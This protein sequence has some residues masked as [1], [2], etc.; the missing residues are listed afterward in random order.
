MLT[1]F[2]HW[3]Y[4]KIVPLRKQVLATNEIYHV[5][6]R[7]V[8]SQ[9]IFNSDQDRR[10]FLDLVDF[11]RFADPL[12]SFSSYLKLEKG[13]RDRYITNL[14]EQGKT[15]IEI[16][17]Y[18]LM[19]NHFHFLLR[20]VVE[21]GIL[22]TLSN[23]QNAYAKYINLKN[24]RAGPLFQS[25]F[26]AVRV[27]TDDVFLHISRYIHLNPGTAYLVK[28]ENLDSYGWSSCPEYFG[29]RRPRF[30][31]TEEI[32]EMSGGIDNY[33]GFVLNQLDYQRKMDQIKHLLLE[34]ESG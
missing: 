2:E 9:P 34:E 28:A 33:R 29:H 22:K 18:C 30:T 19:P 32:L 6:N 3:V 12:M 1:S 5:L 7:G 24:R 4:I 14:R 11:Y 10:R 31:N 13:V 27:S 16:F 21:E 17:S 26:R 15:K 8:A 20:Q 25:R 23:I